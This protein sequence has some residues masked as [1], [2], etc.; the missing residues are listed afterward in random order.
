MEVGWTASSG[1]VLKMFTCGFEIV[2][3]SDW[4][5]PVSSKGRRKRLLAAM[6]GPRDDV[7]SAI[8]RSDCSRN[9]VCRSA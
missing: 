5:E 7:R 1:M 2:L 8:A 9:Q 4:A 6:L 3:S